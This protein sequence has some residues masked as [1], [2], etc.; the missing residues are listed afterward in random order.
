MKARSGA[1]LHGNERG[2]D[3]VVAKLWSRSGRTAAEGRCSRRR[4]CW[5]RTG[6]NIIGGCPGAFSGGAVGD[7]A[8]MAT[9]V[10]RVEQLPEITRGFAASAAE[11]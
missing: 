6:K 11:R 3:Q 10:A 7:V 2:G 4:G 5:C 1:M 9:G 8:G